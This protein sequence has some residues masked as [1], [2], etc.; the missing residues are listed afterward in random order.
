MWQELFVA[1]GLVLVRADYRAAVVQP[2]HAHDYS[3]ITLMLAGAVEESVGRHTAR[4]SALGVV[5]KSAGVEHACHWG[6]GGAR[7]LSVELDPAVWSGTLV[8]RP[9]VSWSWVNRAESV[10]ALIA[11]YHAASDGSLETEADDLVLELVASLEMNHPPETTP[12]P[13]LIHARDEIRDTS[14][15]RPPTRELAARA[16]V[17]PVHFARVFRQHTGMSPTTFAR[18]HRISASVNAL[19]SLPA[20]E[21]GRIAHGHGFSDH[22]HFCR[23]LRRHIGLSPS[24]LRG[25]AAP[26]APR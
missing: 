26:V 18:W 9:L 15:R 12:P 19:T 24:A 3:S 23:E 1:R 25:L 11:L 20:R 4:G 7:T 8:D 10:A 5:V 14:P 21:V 16:G 13:W 2:R 17:H 22:S 6:L